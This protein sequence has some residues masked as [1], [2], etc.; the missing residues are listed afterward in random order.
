MRVNAHGIYHYYLLLTLPRSKACWY[1]A[2]LILF[3]I[4]DVDT[5][6]SSDVL[7][8]SHHAIDESEIEVKLDHFCPSIGECCLPGGVRVLSG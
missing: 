8:A 7:M 1:T 6:Q 2:R 5:K 3:L 4:E